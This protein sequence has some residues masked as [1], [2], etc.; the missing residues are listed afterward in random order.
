MNVYEYCAVEDVSDCL[1]ILLNAHML[2]IDDLFSVLDY[3]IYLK[4]KNTFNITIKTI[5]LLIKR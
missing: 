2:G 4:S 5:N 3:S 1:E